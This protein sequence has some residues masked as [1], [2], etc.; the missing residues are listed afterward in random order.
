MKYIVIATIFSAT[1]LNALF[2][3][4]PPNNSIESNDNYSLFAAC[5]TDQD[6]AADDL[7]DRSQLNFEEIASNLGVKNSADLRAA[8]ASPPPYYSQQKLVPDNDNL[9]NYPD[10]II[11]YDPPP[12]PPPFVAAGP[13]KPSDNAKGE[14]LIG[15]IHDELRK[16]YD[17]CTKL[18]NEAFSGI[19]APLGDTTHDHIEKGSSRLKPRSNWRC[20]GYRMGVNDTYEDILQFRCNTAFMTSEQNCVLSEHE[21]V[22]EEG[23]FK[24][25]N[26]KENFV[27]L[28]NYFYYNLEFNSILNISRNLYQTAEIRVYCDRDG[29]WEPGFWENIFGSSLFGVKTGHIKVVQLAPYSKYGGPGFVEKYIPPVKK[30]VLNGLRKQYLGKVAKMNHIID[31][32]SLSGSPCSSLGISGHASIALA[33]RKVVWD[34]PIES[35]TNLSQ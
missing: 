10:N 7:V 11:I 27:K 26:E 16:I 28:S 29:G 20:G 15:V 17:D 19:E 34:I 21:L 12:P 13:P 5:L 3:G 35:G 1:L 32:E 30:A 22:D 23:F 14:M 2:A 33:D 9:L 8:A 31:V 4:T 6:V 25:E 24:C 18:T